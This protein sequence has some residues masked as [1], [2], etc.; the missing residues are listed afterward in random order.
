[1]HLLLLFQ[2]KQILK[3][4]PDIIIYFVIQ[5]EQ[6]DL[7][8]NFFFFLFKASWINQV[9]KFLKCKENW[10]ISNSI[11]MNSIDRWLFCK[12]ISKKYKIEFHR[13]NSCFYK[14]QELNV[15]SKQFLV[16]KWKLLLKWKKFILYFF[17]ASR[18]EIRID[19]PFIS[20][21]KK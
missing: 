6:R 4:L 20:N 2:N 15:Q 11:Q 19:N 12:K 7:F 17:L 9:W 14:Y 8:L 10:L 16:L 21:P 1:M 5:L 18:H 3:F 13:L